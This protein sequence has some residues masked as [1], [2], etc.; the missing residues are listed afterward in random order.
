GRGPLGGLLLTLALQNFPCRTGQTQRAPA[1]FGLQLGQDV[2]AVRA[3]K[4]TPHLELAGLIVVV[5][6]AQPQ[7][8]PEPEATTDQKRPKRTVSVVLAELD[9]LSYLLGAEGQ[10]LL[11]RHVRGLGSGFVAIN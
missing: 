3:S 6:P 2:L 4:L 8:L 9:Q 11:V 5:A 1:G 7:R 10:H